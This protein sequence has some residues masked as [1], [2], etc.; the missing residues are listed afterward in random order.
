MKFHCTLVR[1][2]ESGLQDAP[3]ELTIQAP[4][5]TAGAHIQ[6][7]LTRQFGAGGVSVS[8]KALQSLTV[9][10]A[11][12]VNGA[13]LIEGAALH[14]AR[15]L[16]RRAPADDARLALAVH[17]GVGAGIVVPLRRGSYTIGR[18]STRIVIPDPELSR[19]HARLDVTETDIMIIDLDSANGVDV[20]GER[21]RNA[22]ISTDSVIR[23]GNTKMSLVLLDLPE[24]A[25][26]DAG[27]STQEPLTVTGRTEASNRTVL[28][29]TAALPLL[30]GVGLAV[31]TGMWMFLAFSAASAVSVLVPLAAGRRQRR[32]LAKAV[33]AAVEEDRKRRR[34]AGPSLACL[35]LAARQ[36]QGN[37]KEG[38]QRPV[39][40]TQTASSDD[41]VEEAGVWLRLGEASQPPNV[42]VEPGYPSA[43]LPSAGIVPVALDPDIARTTFRGPE[44]VADGL[45]RSLV[46]QLA[47]YPRARTTR[48]LIV[49]DAER[50]PL[51]AR[52]LQGSTLTAS[53]N[54]ARRIL[55][56]GFGSAHQRGVLIMLG[57]SSAQDDDTTS[58]LAAGLGWQV[59][60]FLP[61]AGG[62][63]RPWEAVISERTSILRSPAG[64]VAF[65]PDLAPEAV[66]SDFCRNLAGQPAPPD[67]GHNA[68]PSSCSLSDF[69]PLSPAGVAARWTA[70]AQADGLPV[71]M[72][73]SATGTHGLDL[74]SDG[75]HLLVAGTTGSGKSEL[76]RTLALALALS[77][78]PDRVNFL[79]VDFKGGS[80]LSPLTKLV[81]CV[82]LLTDLSTYELERTMAS[83]R[84][85]IRLREEA[86]AAAR[87]PDL[88]SY[89]STWA[90]HNFPLPHLVIVIDEFRMLVDDAPEVLRELMRIAAIG[91]SLGIHLVMA[92]QRP[93]GAV[94]ADIRANVTSSIALR[95]QSDMES[96]DIINTKD[97]AGISVGT[98]GR[99]FMARGTE[100]PQEFQ[101]ATIGTAPGGSDRADVFK[102][103]RAV[104]CFTS[105]GT[106]DAGRESSGGQPSGQRTPTQAAQ[107]L[108]EIVQDLWHGQNGP[109]P[110][111]PVAAPLPSNLP[112]PD[113]RLPAVHPGRGKGA[114]WMTELGLMDLP[115]EQKVVP[116]VWKPPEHSHLALVGGPSS[117]ALDA[118][119]FAVS[120]LA[121]HP[122]EAHCYLLDAGGTFRGLA[123]SGR[124]GAQVGTHE[125][126]RA[127]RVLERLKQEMARRLSRG[128][129]KGEVP[130]VLAISGWGSWI[131]ALRAGPLAWAE[132][133][134]QDLARDGSRAD[135]VV[136]LEGDRE[137]VSSRTFALLA[138]RLY[139]PTGSNPDS[140][141][142]W[143]RMP[144]TA[145][146]KGRAVAFGPIAGGGPAVSQL[147]RPD[148]EILSKPGLASATPPTKRPFRIEPLPA[149]VQ[150]TK[151][152]SSATS[153]RTSSLE[154]P[155]PANSAPGNNNGANSSNGRPLLIGVGGDELEPASISLPYGG[156]LTVL[157][158]PGSGK[159]NFLK[160]LPLMNPAGG[161]W[162]RREADGDPSE[163]W[164]KS[165]AMAA[166]GRTQPG[167]V[168]L[169]DDADLLNAEALQH[170]W[171]L[172]A[173]GCAVVLTA[174]YSPLLSQRVPLAMKSR[175]SGT[176]VLLAPRS[177]Q[178]GDLF[179][180]R[181]EVEAHPPPGRGV[182][183]SRSV[184]RSIQVGWANSNGPHT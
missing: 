174:N 144:A 83:L 103:Q 111:R 163:Y 162:L 4:E 128:G 35:V 145:R 166:A 61:A 22:V 101:T 138:N 150:A 88:A 86:L 20:D 176:G 23:C 146:H 36:K 68:V 127:V 139:F 102:V 3:L 45:V 73:I 158:G 167:T 112:V 54:D 67:K 137:L 27:M 93:Q 31:I 18:S 24:R 114:G 155:K 91:R 183:I 80:G 179:G 41:G 104:D 89:R 175:A 6:S 122:V 181:F 39:G 182:L 184:A 85:E 134:V 172:N 44:A 105:H 15:N 143:P 50:L 142:A 90:S 57:T 96:C 100:A 120:Q 9:G 79:F 136:M 113:G 82:G 130:L 37:P 12:L 43:G 69:L 131:S 123:P 109:A 30:I 33:A 14:G 72:G 81:H 64:E 51:A 129:M 1:S 173:L 121:L 48:V 180:T 151:I 47:G 116:L 2:Q 84:A 132:D 170:L 107:P 148:P 135:I 74:V 76:L 34:L 99:A 164:Q 70:S 17:S 153:N 133:L 8:S 65:V 19:E 11:P 53:S 26:A 161:P 29:L 108:V 177:L 87:V 16:R 117:G 160:A 149:L 40:K 28:V 10:E 95:V 55:A 60:Q 110:R 152:S 71:P 52:Y 63:D 98:P 62:G 165:V 13:V 46:M 94:T 124:V 171:E 178:D 49:G 157:G 97:A 56:E 159:T 115:E 7:Q 154:S 25:L 32:E 141:I 58:A 38:S 75:P 92:T 156:V 168:A 42:K 169:V 125:L 126:R 147:Y 66:F 78:P 118:L 59:L 21:V 140:R 77:H 5:G 119:E 106:S